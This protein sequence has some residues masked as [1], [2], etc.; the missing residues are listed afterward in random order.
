MGCTHLYREDIY[1]GIE[2]LCIVRILNSYII[3]MV[4]KNEGNVKGE[5]KSSTL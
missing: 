3:K 1:P 2:S 5:G 4:I